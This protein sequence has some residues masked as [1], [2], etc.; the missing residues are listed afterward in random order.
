MTHAQ[1]QLLGNAEDLSMTS[2]S[3][4]QEIPRTFRDWSPAANSISWRI[5]P[6]DTARLLNLKL[7]AVRQ[8]SISPAIT[9]LRTIALQCNRP[10][11]IDS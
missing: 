9:G 8:H 10:A 2:G 11:M 7:Q 3:S 4:G 1:I 5:Q 6:L